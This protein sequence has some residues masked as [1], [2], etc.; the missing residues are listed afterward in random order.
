MPGD[1][2]IN[3]H[4]FKGFKGFITRLSLNWKWTPGVLRNYRKI[5]K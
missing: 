1:E 5:Y 3:I 4:P 2:I